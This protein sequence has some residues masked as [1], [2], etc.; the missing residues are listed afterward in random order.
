M[1]ER[2]GNACA[3]CREVRRL[4]V[5]H[6]HKT[7]RVR[8]LLCVP[9]PSGWG[10]LRVGEIYLG[11]DA[12]ICCSC[13][14]SKPLGEFHRR[15]ASHD[16]RQSRCKDCCKTYMASYMA[17]PDNRARQI[18]NVRA[19]MKANPERWA[20]I[21]GEATRAYRVRRLN[22]KGSHTQAEWLALCEAAGHRCLCC[23]KKRK[24][25]RDHVVPLSQGGTDDID[26]IQPLCGPCNSSKNAKVI[27]YRLRL[28]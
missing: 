22:C 17:D 3:I 10:S 9:Y 25:T 13:R 27:D 5:D 11:M 23:G 8:G 20:A 1:A 19:W 28:S 14:V 6:D 24:L 18:V 4:V 16:G 26:N 21:R 15:K 12:K 2:Q 7:G